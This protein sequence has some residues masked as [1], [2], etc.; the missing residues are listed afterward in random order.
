V[1]RNAAWALGQIGSS[2]SRNALTVAA[3]DKSGLVRNVARASL[4]LLH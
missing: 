2:A 1:R 4:G 3:S